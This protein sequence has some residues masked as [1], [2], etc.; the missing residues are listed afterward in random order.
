MDNDSSIAQIAAILRE[1][2]ARLG[3]GAR[4]PSSR[5]IMRRHNVSPVTVS[6][7]IGQLAAEGRVVTKPG[8]GAFVARH[9]R[10]VT[11][12]EA[13]DLSWQTVALGDRVVDEGPVAALLAG[14]PDGAV[15]LT[16]GYLHPGLRPD[17]HLAAAAA[18]AVRRPGAWDKPPL[19]GLSELRRWFAGQ[20]GGDVTA[21]DVLIVSGGQAALTHAFRALAAPGT[22]VLVETPTY[23]GALA[24]AKAA[25]LRATAVPMDVDGVR[26]EL[27][28]EA[29]AVTGA[30]VFLCQPTL[31]NPTG[32][33]LPLDRRRQVLQVARAA[34]AFVIEDDYAHYLTEQPP[35]TL[36]SMDEHGTVVHVRSLTKILS[37]SVRVAAVIARGPA[38]HRLRAGQLVESF[39]VARPLQETALELVGSAAWRR[40]LAAV[41]AEIRLRRD[42]LAAALAT[43]LPA[44]AELHLLPAGGMHLWLRLPADLDEGA[45][46]EA[47]RR[48]GVLV[49]PGRMYYPSEPPGPRLRLTHIA[50]A[51]LAELTEGVRRLGR[52]F[53]EIG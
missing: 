42:A 1:E 33:T 53:A 28:A 38:A 12:R 8:S 21:A 36:A 2:A 5:E 52:A 45:L 31:H 23:P 26:P 9:Q 11:G 35:P 24:A 14:A 6:R 16:G 49:S 44:G 37:P 30:R 18:R 32:A 41:H 10:P 19:T 50:A 43:H 47:A 39:F 25:G 40:H 46:V 3:P 51:H 15:P 13:A 34:G 22:P 17:R 4:L 7:A 48:N 20:T 27:L 29:F